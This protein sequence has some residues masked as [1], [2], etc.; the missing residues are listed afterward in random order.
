MTITLYG[1]DILIRAPI[2]LKA[3]IKALP[4]SRWDPRRRVWT[5]PATRTAARAAVEAFGQ[6]LEVS[7]EVRRLADAP[8]SPYRDDPLPVERTPSWRHQRA[9]FWFCV[10]QF[11]DKLEGKHEA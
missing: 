5:L 3:R 10:E 11:G 2:S 1:P 7:A 9:A 4:G 8:A 6:V